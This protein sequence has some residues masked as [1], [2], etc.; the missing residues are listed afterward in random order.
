MGRAQSSPVFDST[1]VSCVLRTPSGPRRA[2][3]TLM[4]IVRMALCQHHWIRHAHTHLAKVAALCSGI[5]GYVKEDGQVGCWQARV[6]RLAP[7]QVQPLRERA[8]TMRPGVS[9]S[10]VI[11]GPRAVLSV[12]CGAYL[13]CCEGDAREGVAVQHEGR[14]LLEVLLHS[15]PV[16]DTLAH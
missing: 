1:L 11:I 6:R 13:C 12:D 5:H 7:L 8:T 4:S 10:W 3:S 16:K 14:A 9:H 2:P 15:V